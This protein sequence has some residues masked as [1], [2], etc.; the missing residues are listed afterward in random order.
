MLDDTVP[1]DMQKG[2]ELYCSSFF[3]GCEIKLKRPG[4]LWQ[5]KK[6]PLDFIAENKIKERV[7]YG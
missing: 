5:Q 2:L 6:L 3:L 4:D 1:D 7:H